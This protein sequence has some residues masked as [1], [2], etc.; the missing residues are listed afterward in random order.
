MPSWAVNFTSDSLQNKAN[1]VNGMRQ[2]TKLASVNWST[3]LHSQISLWQISSGPHLQYV[4][5]LDFLVF[6]IYRP[7]AR[8][9]ECEI[10]PQLRSRG[11]WGPTDDHVT[12]KLAL[13]IVMEARLRALLQTL[14]YCTICEKAIMYSMTAKC[15][16]CPLSQRTHLFSMWACLCS[17]RED[18]HNSNCSL[19]LSRFSSKKIQPYTVK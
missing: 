15:W 14:Y 12:T 3:A 13:S 18:F 17:L 10:S 2:M 4:T 9:F 19:F 8:L 7:N 16:K 1:F 6:S 11:G 5:L